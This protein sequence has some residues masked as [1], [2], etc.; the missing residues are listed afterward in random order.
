MQFST[1]LYD[2]FMYPFEALGLR[3][4][5]RLMLGHAK[6]SLLEVGTGSGAN[7]KHIPYERLSGYTGLDRGLKP[8]KKPRRLPK[9]FPWQL[10][11]GSVEALPFEDHS[12][13]T[14][15]FTLVFCSVEDPEKGLE[16]VRRV[17]RPGGTLLFIEHVLP[18]HRVL[19]PIFHKATPAWRQVAGNCHLNRETVKLIESKGFKIQ[20]QKRFLQGV[21]VCGCARKREE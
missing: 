7:F 15:L 2:A 19:A 21:F 9:D 18:D 16:E 17:L 1:M 20:Q 11:E 4:M 12:F 13:D 10:L 6:G 8:L 3:R 5:R 14:V